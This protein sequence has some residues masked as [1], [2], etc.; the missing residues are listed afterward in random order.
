[1]P[2][3]VGD[4]RQCLLEH[5]DVIIGVVRARIAATQLTSEKLPGVVAEREHRVMAN[6][7]L[8]VAAASSFSE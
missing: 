7:P 5:G 8:N 3:T 4:L 2:V 6:D 1:M